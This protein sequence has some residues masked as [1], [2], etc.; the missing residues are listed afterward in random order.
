M[1]EKFD[2]IYADSINDEIEFDVIFGGEGSL[3][4]SVDPDHFFDESGEEITDESDEVVEENNIEEEI[5]ESENVASKISSM[6][7]F[8]SFLEELDI[9]NES[10]FSED[11]DDDDD[12]DDDD[13]DGYTGYRSSDND[14]DDDD[15]DNDDD[16][17]GSNHDYNR[18]DHEDK[19]KYHDFDQP[20]C[21]P[22]GCEEKEP[23]TI[24]DLDKRIARYD[25]GTNDYEKQVV[26]SGET[27]TDDVRDVRTV[28]DLDRYTNKSFNEDEEEDNHLIDKVDNDDGTP[29]EEATPADFH[30][31]EDNYQDNSFEVRDEL[32]ESITISDLDSAIGLIPTGQSTLGDNIGLDSEESEEPS[33]EEAFEDG[34]DIDS[35]MDESFFFD[36]D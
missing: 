3:I 33:S 6:E 31:P 13:N 24:D 29:D 15:I 17:Y 26:H 27:K 25:V 4:E 8:D 18:D 20:R 35:I 23:V 28:D 36:F 30:R 7:D 22:N 16:Y 21:E 11:H 14:D 32:K 1:M 5:E 2:S 9:D 34:E 12:S 10:P 19:E